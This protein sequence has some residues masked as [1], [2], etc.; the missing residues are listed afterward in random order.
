MNELFGMLTSQLGVN[1]TQAKGGVGAIL[2]LAKDKLGE[3]DFSQILNSLGDSATEAMSAAPAAEGGGGIGG[4]LGGAASALGVDLGGLGKLGALAGAFKSLDLDAGM[5]GK[6]A[7]IVMG[8]VKE[9]GGDGVA[10][11]LEGLMK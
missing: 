11:I 2:N 4:M 5:I 8:F 3:G 7:P 9:K 10:G 6:F 1:D